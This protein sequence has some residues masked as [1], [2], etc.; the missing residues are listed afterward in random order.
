[1]QHGPLAGVTVLDLTSYIAGPFAASLLADLGADIIKVEA[2][3]GDMMRHYPS[4]VEG[5]SRVFLGVNR[6][7]KAIVID[8]KSE[9]GKAVMR[10]LIEKADV[11]IENFRPSVPPRLGLDYE[12]LKAQNPRLIYCALTGYGESGPQ[13]D[14]AGYDQVLQAMT[15][16]A[17]F[18]GAGINAPPLTVPGSIVDFYAAS[19]AALGIAAALH[20][21]AVTGQGQYIATSLLSASLAMQAGRFVNVDGEPRDID[22]ELKPGKLAAIH[23]TKDGYI[24]ISAHTQAFWKNLCRILELDGLAADPRYD[25]IR[26]RSEHA[27]ELLPIIHGALA[28]RTAKEWEKLMAG[29]VPCAVAQ[30]IEDAFDHPQIIAEGLV[31]HFPHQK[32]GG[33]LGLSQPIKFAACDGVTPIGAPA[34]GQHTDEILERL[35]WSAETIAKMRANG[36]VA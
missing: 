24:Y 3:E 9:D 20:Q 26:K 1:M 18:H 16:I 25:N 28:K 6:G 34:L 30:P 10:G 15:G 2:P 33:Y 31:A 11:F 13:R 12:T 8:L 14:N 22:R 27:D 7:K 32:L 23:P 4:S 5:E 17:V 19:M 21:R 35:G 29:D 36:A